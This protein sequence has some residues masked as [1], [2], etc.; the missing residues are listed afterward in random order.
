M[1]RTVNT[2]LLFP[3]VF[4]FILQSLPA[5]VSQNITLLGHWDE[6]AVPTNFFNDR[7][8]EVWGFE[9]NGR[10]YAVIGSVLGTHFIDVTDPVN[11]VEVDYVAGAYQGD[12]V[13]HRDYHDYQD[14]LYMVCDEGPSTVQIADLSTLPDSVTMVY[15]SDALFPNCH[16]VFVDSSSGLLYAC[17]VKR[18]TGWTEMEVYSLTNPALP[19]LVHSHQGFTSHDVYV[20]NDTVYQHAETNGMFVFDYSNPTNPQPIGALTGYP[21][22][23]YN[24]SGWLNEGGD[25][26]AFADEDHGYDVKICDVSDISNIQVLTTVSSG[27]D[28]DSS[29]PHNLMIKD[30]Y[31]YVSYYNDGLYIYDIK[32]PSQPVISGYY[33]TY[34]GTTHVSYKGAWGVYCFLPSGNILVSDM[35]TGLYI[36]DVSLA[37]GEEEAETPAPRLQ[38]YP[39][40]SNGK[41]QIYRTGPVHTDLTWTLS[42]LSGRKVS[43]GKLE[44]YANPEIDLGRVED[45]V[46]LFNLW[47]NGRRAGQERV[48]IK[49][50]R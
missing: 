38:L 28:P 23:G 11:P 15:D 1:K 9:R 33:D 17:S 3:F 50:G 40:P 47:E 19:S 35:S 16:N 39:N 29:M 24:H 6:P 27:I 26:Y 4:I 37:L 22:K 49:R 46:Y 21:D 5:Q 31:M 8:S 48:R 20:R 42:D 36:F 2:S 25:I 30:G 43:A 12:F 41:L 14:H 7:Y 10:E 44:P 34:P 13:I 45:G 18:Y 32:D